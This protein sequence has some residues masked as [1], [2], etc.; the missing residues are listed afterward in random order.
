VWKIPDA[1]KQHQKM[2]SA[3]TCKL[4]ADEFKRI[5]TK[6][7]SE[8][9]CVSRNVKY[10][11]AEIIAIQIQPREQAHIFQSTSQLIHI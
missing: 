7:L 10:V 1:L 4:R 9:L 5:P 6:V 8:E 11:M 3:F 2:T